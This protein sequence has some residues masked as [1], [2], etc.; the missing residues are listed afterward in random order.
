MGVLKLPLKKSFDVFLC[1]CQAGSLWNTV[2]KALGASREAEKKDEKSRSQAMAGSKKEN[3]RQMK[4]WGSKAPK[5]K[6]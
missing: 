2:T 5:L 6:C 4:L 1:S 3:K